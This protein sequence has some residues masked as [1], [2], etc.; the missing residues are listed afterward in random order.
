VNPATHFVQLVAF[1]EGWPGL[2]EAL[3]RRHAD[4]GTGHCGQCTS[5]GQVGRH[6]WPCQIRLAAERAA[7]GGSAAE[8]GAPGPSG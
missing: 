8:G 7:P 4:D 3:T 5:G 6:V 2:A 1:I